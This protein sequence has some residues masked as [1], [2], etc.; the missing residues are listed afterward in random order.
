[1]TRAVSAARRH[2]PLS[3]TNALGVSY[4]HAFASLLF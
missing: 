2:V 1:V 4:N 3:E